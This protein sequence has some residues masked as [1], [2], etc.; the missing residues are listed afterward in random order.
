MILKDRTRNIV[1]EHVT[2]WRWDYVLREFDRDSTRMC[3]VVF[4]GP[5]GEAFMEPDASRVEAFLVEHLGPVLE[6]LTS[7]EGT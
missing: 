6:P 1:L 4:C 3:L 7:P 2:G 5:K